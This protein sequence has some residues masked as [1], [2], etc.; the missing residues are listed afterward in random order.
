MA[1][2]Y[3][4]FRYSG[5]NTIRFVVFWLFLCGFE[6]FRPPLRPPPYS[7]KTVH[8]L[9]SCLRIKARPAAFSMMWCVKSLFVKINMGYWTSMRSRWLQIAQVLSSVFM[10]TDWDWVP[11]SPYNHRKKN[12]TNNKTNQANIQ[13]SWPIMDLLYGFL[14]DAVGSFR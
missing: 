10:F 11:Y 12:N 9:W 7:L 13:S 6:V 14:V 2:M 8:V 3:V 5:K 4:R 1:S